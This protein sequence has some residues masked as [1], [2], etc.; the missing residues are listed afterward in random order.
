MSDFVAQ[1]AADGADTRHVVFV[2]DAVCQQFVAD[3]PGEDAG[4]A[5][6]VH[7]DVLH[8]LGCGDAGFAPADGAREDRAGFVVSRQDFADTAVTDAQLPTDVAGP[9]AQLR[10]FDDAESNSGWK[11]PA[12]DEHPAQ[13]VH[14]AVRRLLCFYKTKLLCRVTSLIKF[15]MLC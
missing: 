10:H 14:L 12:V 1:N 11:R 15:R 8:D 4:V 3:L 5:L 6:L 7:L 9:N 13:L 2:A